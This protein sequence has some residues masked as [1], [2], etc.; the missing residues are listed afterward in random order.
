MKLFY[1]DLETTGVRFWK[2]GIHQISGAI[3][4]DGDVK[5]E[6]NFHVKPYKDAL[7]EDEALKIGGITRDDLNDYAEMSDV[8]DQI[9]SMLARYVDRYDKKDK[10]FIV[11]YNNAS[12]DNA[13]FRAFF[14]QNNDEYF[15]SWFWSVPIDVMI[16]AQQFLMGLRADM[17]DF[18]L[19]T[20]AAHLGMNV[21]EDQ[22]HNATYDIHLTRGLYYLVTATKDVAW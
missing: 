11:G 18:K 7:I 15:G 16:L 4:I 9:V 8:Y 12:F 17:P 13:F 5:E 20:V 22:L 2:N 10:F 21:E 1:L 19:K 14:K 6:F 3:E